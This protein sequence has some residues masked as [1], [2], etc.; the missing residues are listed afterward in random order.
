MVDA[1]SVAALR[2]RTTREPP[3]SDNKDATYVNVYVSVDALETEYAMLVLVLD[4]GHCKTDVKRKLAT[5]SLSLAASFARG[6]MMTKDFRI[7]TPT[8]VDADGV[9]EGV[10]DGV[11]PAAELVVDAV[12]EFVADARFEDDSDG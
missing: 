7:D 6:T 12:G 10:G 9:S 8:I 11:P 3:A 2:R 1:A 4:A 5:A